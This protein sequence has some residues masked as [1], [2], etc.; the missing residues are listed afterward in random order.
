MLNVVKLSVMAPIRLNDH[1]TRQVQVLVK[2]IYRYIL[3]DEGREC[4]FNIKTLQL[5]KIL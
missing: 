2:W 1:F 3:T 5:T 4:L